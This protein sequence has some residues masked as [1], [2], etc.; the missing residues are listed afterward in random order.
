MFKIGLSDR[1]TYPVNVEVVGDGG[2]RS[3][4]TFDAVFKRLSRDEIIEVT[5]RARDGESDDLALVRDVLLGWK[6][7]QDDD[8]AELPFSEE[9][10][11]RVLSAWPVLPSVVAAF[12]EATSPKGKAKN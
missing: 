7:I 8:G 4:Y 3:T 9:N 11:E 6:G 2:K 1:F 5:T 10:R 12:I